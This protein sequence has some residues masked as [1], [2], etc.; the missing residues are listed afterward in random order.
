MSYVQAA[1]YD[2]ATK[3]GHRYVPYHHFSVGGG[4]A[5]IEAAVIAAAYNTLVYYLGDPAGVL[6]AALCGLDRRASRQQEHCPGNCRR[7]GGGRGYRG[8]AS[9]R[10]T[11]RGVA[12]AERGHT[13]Q[14]CAGRR[15]GVAAAAVAADRPNT[16]DGGHAALHARQHLAVPGAAAER[17]D[18][19]AVHH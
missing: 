11:Q 19:H 13:D 1:V 6:A 10:R 5:S 2:A 17:A 4:N 12:R 7:R 14:S 9:E 3:I 8:T 18:E 15:V 16:V